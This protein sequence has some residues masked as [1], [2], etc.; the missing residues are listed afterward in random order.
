[1]PLLDVRCEEEFLAGHVPG[2]VNIPLAEL[3]QRLHELPDRGATLHLVKFDDADSSEA[4]TFLEQRGLEVLPVTATRD[5]L[6]ESGPSSARLWQPNAFLIEALAAINRQSSS[7]NPPLRALDVACG[8]GRDAVYFAMNG[9][10]VD[11]IDLLPDALQRANDLASRHRVQIRTIQQDLQT[12]PVLPAGQYDLIVVFRYL[13]RSLMPALSKALRPGGYLVYETFHEQ[14][15]QTGLKPS[16]PDHLLKTGE[17][18]SSFSE[19]EIL[20]ADDAFERNGRY[21]SHLLARRWEPG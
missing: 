14:N 4:Q 6:T 19:L 15:R 16:N 11:A 21:F 5:E 17:L 9:Y 1:M 10:Q 8:S 13:Q 18:A 12:Q 2:A 7:A 20:I 3:T